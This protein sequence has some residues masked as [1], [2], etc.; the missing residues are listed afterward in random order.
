MTV[1]IKITFTATS[2][3]LFFALILCFLARFDL[4][5]D[6]NLEYLLDIS[7]LLKIQGLDQVSSNVFDKFFVK[8]RFGEAFET[9]ADKFSINLELVFRFRHMFVQI[10]TTKRSI[11]FR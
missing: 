3:E 4:F 9:S 1:T 11:R 8:G 5:I 2:I 6:L 7:R 10:Y